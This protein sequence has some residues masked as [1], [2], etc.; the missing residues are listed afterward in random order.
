MIDPALLKQLTMIG[1]GFAAAFLAA[2]WLSLIFWTFRDIR[3]RSRD[4]LMRI[5]A[6]VVAALL[7]LPGILIYLV[8]RP[9][10]TLEE[11]YQHALEEE[12]LLQSIEDAS[13]CP[14]CNRHVHADWVACPS[15]HTV[16]K[17]ACSHCGKSLEL[18]WSLCPYCGSPVPGAKTEPASEASAS[19]LFDDLEDLSG[20]DEPQDQS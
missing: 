18:T 2:L 20:G 6:V 7:F 17:K 15:C 16:L 13:L 12:A 14:G 9:P 19:S 10:R 11:D 1:T 4:P 3:S 8:L 5:L